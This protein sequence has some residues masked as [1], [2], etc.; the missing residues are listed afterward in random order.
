MSL[1]LEALKK[2]EKAKTEA[3][4]RELELAPA[5]APGA[6]K[7]VL[8]RAELPDI[9]QPLE[10]ASD[11][12]A[13]NATREARVPPQVAPG[14]S[15]PPAPEAERA[16]AKKVFEA[17]FREPDPRRPFFILLGVLGAAAVGIIVYFWYQLRPPPLLVQLNPPRAASEQTVAASVSVPAPEPQAAPVAAIAGL[18]PL[19]AKPAPLTVSD[20]AAETAAPTAAEPL[21]P[22]S[23]RDAG[24][25]APRASR[26]AAQAAETERI[27]PLRF[28][29]PQPAVHPQVDSGYAAYV[30]GDLVRARN[31]YEQALREDP[32]NRD[33]LLGLAALES[34]SGRLPRAEALYAKLLQSDPRDAHAQAGL[35][36][37]RAGRID[38]VLAESRV[39]TLLAS[40]PGAA[41]LHF[42]LGNQLAQQG[43]WPE[44]QQAY[45]KAFAA[46]PQNADFAYNLAVS[47]DQLRQPKLALDYYQ[48]ALALA[49][50]VNASFDARAARERVGQLER[51]QVP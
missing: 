19:P 17:K 14:A 22:A 47:L 20:S 13:P 6:Q 32:A 12:L 51:S 44:A 16:A 10:I 21:A 41:V 49:E 33:A 15:P 1:L 38:P 4:K 43:R 28:T 11:D 24:R 35:I 31:D 50:K 27:E 46:E 9:R 3:Q 7:H 40:D 34:R 39:K 25:R 42:T 48:R 45:F 23:A 30:A 18:P 8:T 2:A 36:G 29:R 5:S 37:L 26:P